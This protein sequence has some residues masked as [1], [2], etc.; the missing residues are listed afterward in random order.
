MWSE[1]NHALGVVQRFGRRAVVVASMVFNIFISIALV[2]IN[3]AIFYHHDFHYG[4]FLTLVHFVVCTI[5]LR[6][7]VFLGLI[8]KK[9]IQ[10]KEVLLLSFMHALFV[11]LNNLSLQYNSV[12]FYQVMKAFTIPVV[13]VI[14]SFLY[15]LHFSMRLKASLALTCLGIGMATFTDVNLNAMGFIIA[16]LG[17]FAKAGSQVLT[18]S[19]HKDLNL[20]SMQ[21]LYYQAPVSTAFLFILTP[22]FDDVS[23]G[24]NGLAGFDVDMSLVNLIGCS[25]VL[26]FLFNLSNYFLIDLTGPLT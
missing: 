6:L 9:S 19:K 16:V 8:Q 23:S 18:G 22:I 3:K 15:Q 7:C 24:P 20:N 11:T 25:S 14:Q 21:L 13:V 12:G 26:A 4:T 2:T 10:Y 17:E 1:N 5:G